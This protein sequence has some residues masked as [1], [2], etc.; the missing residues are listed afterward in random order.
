MQSPGFVFSNDNSMDLVNSE[1]AILTQAAMTVSGEPMYV[2]VLL[3]IFI[4]L[5][6]SR[7]AYGHV[8]PRF[9]RPQVPPKK[10]RNGQCLA[11]GGLCKPVSV[12]RAWAPGC[13]RPR[14]TLR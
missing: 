9:S 3:D 10:P 8:R 14:H 6:D 2:W 12:S 4:L 1:P 5:S 13:P 7:N 11:A